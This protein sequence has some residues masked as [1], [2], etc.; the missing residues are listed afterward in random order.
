MRVTEI[1]VRGLKR[2]DPSFIHGILNQC[3]NIDSLSQLK[4]VL[5]RQLETI[6][7]LSL[8]KDVRV[9][10]DGAKGVGSSPEDVRLQVEVEERRYSLKAGTE[11]RQG[12]AAFVNRIISYCSFSP[13]VGLLIMW[14]GGEK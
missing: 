12:E 10:V 13:S 1:E 14:V 4:E 9:L 8:F 2:T 5:S 11:L 6:S 7:R 3:R